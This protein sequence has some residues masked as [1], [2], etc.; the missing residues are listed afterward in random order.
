MTQTPDFCL[1][2]W[3]TCAICGEDK[4]SKV[5]CAVFVVVKH[6]DNDGKHPDQ[7]EDDMKQ[8]GR[9]CAKAK[10]AF[11]EKFGLGQKC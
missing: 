8:G 9:S 4:L 1:G 6:T 7:D 3:E 11:A 2:V 5:H 10:R